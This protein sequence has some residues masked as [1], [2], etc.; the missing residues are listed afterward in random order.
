MN[1]REYEWLVA[2]LGEL[3]DLLATTP[4]SA[5]IDRMSLE[6]RRTEVSEQLDGYT[7]PTRWPAVARLTF[8]GGPV[9]GRRG[10]DAGFAARAV[11]EFSKA[12]ASAGASL[13][14]FLEM[15]GPIPNREQY[16]LLITNVALGSFG[17]EI[18]EATP[19][20]K[21]G[22]S[23]VEMG[24]EQV[25]T[26]L[27]SSVE[28]DDTIA[29]VHPRAL[30]DLHGFLKIVA[31]NRA[32]FSLAFKDYVFRFRDLEQV[33][34][35]VADLN[36]N[37][38]QETE[39]EFDGRFVGYL[40]D[41]RRAEFVNNQTSDILSGRVASSVRNADAIN[42]RLEQDLR[43]RVRV[44]RVRDGKPAYTIIG[45]NVLESLHPSRVLLFHDGGR[46]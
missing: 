18:E 42:D 43:I 45:Y 35:S 13:S 44:R 8:D 30:A 39:N 17:F 37:N 9:A 10:I 12:V 23:P 32:V 7:V 26:L 5:V 2:E 40:P 46:E 34:Q 33:Q 20:N 14:G 19:L 31:D 16:G 28:L 4:S 3:D 36:P 6:S 15:K 21:P 11:G 41:S 38:I 24:I 22:P 25:Q 1:R 29:D 27:K